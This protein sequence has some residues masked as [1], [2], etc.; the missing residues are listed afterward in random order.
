M[1]KIFTERQKEI[2]QL[3]DRGTLLVRG[4]AGCGKTSAS[5]E[6]FKALCGQ[7]KDPDSILVL[8]PQRSLLQ[9]YIDAIHDPDFNSA[10]PQSFLTIGGLAQRSIALFWPLIA[11]EAG[12]TQ[13]KKP[14]VFLTL[15]LAQYYLARQIDPLIDK[16]YFSNISID[17]IRLYSQ[18]I[19]NLNKCAVV[20][21]ALE[22]ISGKLSGAW[23]GKADQ[24]A[25]FAQVQEC[26]MLFR[27]Y[28][29]EQN[30][31]D[32][33]LQIQVLN[34]HLW[35]SFLFRQYLKR[36]YQHL[37]Y[38]NIE[39]D[40]P[41]AHDI[42]EEWLP[43]LQ[44]ALL[45]LDENGGFRT[46]LGADPISAERF[47]RA[48]AQTIRLE[49]KF[50]QP[51]QI[52]AF[53]AALTESISTHKVN[54]PD[55]AAIAQAMEIQ[56]CRFIPEALET[57]AVKVQQLINTENVQAS[58]I[59]ILT[60]FLSDSLLFSTVERFTA[61]GIPI[62][63]FRPSRGLKDEPAVK[64]MLTLAKLAY[65][66]VDPPLIRE[67]VRN[68]LMTTIS[69][70]DLVRADMLAQISFS[71]SGEHPGL[72]PL[73]IEKN[74][75][76][77]RITRQVGQRYEHLRTWLVEQANLSETDLDVFWSRLFGEVLSQEGYNFHLNTTNAGL[78]SQLIHSCRQFRQTVESDSAIAANEVGKVYA[79][80]VET[81]ILSSLN[82]EREHQTQNSILISPAHS[83]LM[84][85]KAVKYQFWLDIGST[86]WWA[87]LDQ[88]LTQPYVLSRNWEEGLRWTD[89]NEYAT[90]Q[91]NLARL[92]EGMLNR[93]TEKVILIPVAT[94]QQ[95]NEERGPLMMAVQT[96]L[97]KMHLQETAS[98]V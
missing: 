29:L 30:L 23:A 68:A 87:R 1:V 94:D 67:D 2:I 49:E 48:T 71:A 93:C 28:C 57:I 72:R 36:R 82:P 79:R 14:P 80:L 51:R 63:A 41:V 8:A 88:P 53:S 40:Y 44:S 35:K 13:Y 22:G 21:F 42:I 34:K 38:E 98:Y 43:D 69:R 17:R 65:Q 11:K 74:S 39:E 20:G 58:D 91:R 78:I 92:V 52:S 56:P 61:L 77:E 96:L 59:A 89:E 64:A 62:Q 95:G 75:L 15:E 55:S 33:S 32:F 31:L 9:P 26:A 84:R 46:F 3:A 25:T 45:T 10:A 6:R 60:P 50:V 85:N 70:C 86:G 12:F 27:Q 66:W 83:F 37:I 47:A 76:R 5:V 24:T 16:G 4:S 7:V 73:D 97:K 19:D 54:G 18:I 81:G 90:N